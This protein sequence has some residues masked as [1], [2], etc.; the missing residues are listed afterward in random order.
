MKL[1]TITNMSVKPAICRSELPVALQLSHV[2]FF[3]M[4]TLDVGHARGSFINRERS[5]VPDAETQSS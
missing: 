1:L 3:K 2:A 5:T 4:T